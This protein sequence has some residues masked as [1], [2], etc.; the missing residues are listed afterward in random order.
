MGG[1]WGATEVLSSKGTQ[2]HRFISVLRGS[3][4]CCCCVGNRLKAVEGS[5]EANEEAGVAA[6]DRDD[7]DLCSVG[8][9]GDGGKGVD[10]IFR[11]QTDRAR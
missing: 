6:L 7:S 2:S 1:R 5:R 8:G 10:L 3:P 11:R 4:C 9:R